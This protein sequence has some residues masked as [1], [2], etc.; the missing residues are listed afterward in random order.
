[1]T[2]GPIR[3]PPDAASGARRRQPS[4]AL[5]AILLAALALAFA[6]MAI[7]P[8]PVGVFQD[9]GI[10]T[11]L[12]K[13]LATGHGFRYLNIPGEPHATHYPPLYPMLLA[14]LWKLS[15]RFPENVL[16]FKLANAVLLAVA[17]AGAYLL[18]RSRVGLG[19][20]SAFL[21][22]AAFTACAPV[23]LLT[24][25]VLSEPMFLAALFPVLYIAERSAASGRNGDA[26]AAGAAGALLGLVRTLG[27]LVVP[28]TV[29]VLAWRRRWRAA[30]VVA[31][32]AAVVLAPWQVWAAAH[33]GEVPRVYL[34]KY[35]AYSTWLTDAVV[36]E[37]PVWV[38]KVAWFNLQR[39]VA[40]GWAT[41][42]V[43]P[44]PAAVRW[45]A[46]A[47]LSALFAGGWWRLVRR[48]PVVAWMMAAYLAVVV[49]WPFTPARFTWGIW[50]LVGCTF[51]LAID[52]LRRWKPPGAART[53][54]LAAMA[55]SLLLVAGYARYNWLGAARGWWTQVE[56][57]VADR[58]RPLGA[59]VMAN[60][61]PDDV[62]ATDDDLLIYLYTGRRAIPNGTFT[63]Q[64][65]LTPQTPDFAVRTLR[66][67]L[68]TYH[69]DW[70]L[71]ST[72]YG[73]YAARGLVEASPPELRI[74]RALSSGAVF[75]PVPRT[76]DR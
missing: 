39:I 58:A 56:K 72:Q 62:V 48:A 49:V 24:V 10:Y 55:A 38:A 22:A 36:G 63:P 50:P 71:A 2:G 35:G 51:G 1:M 52:G 31:L 43:D 68:A 74:V 3:H 26:V 32:S 11:V 69:V 12:A 61:G 7:S 37:G 33:A 70:V 4:E 14:A 41:V 40:Q 5:P 64:E 30:A 60:T 42:A 25:M 8:W 21:V 27:V 75:Q 18:A 46:T 59:W 47:V 34:G 19:R 54:R 67:I 65:H 15:P 17:A 23:I 73:T 53:L 66:E 20:G 29:L 6:A 28:A 9:D 16:V 45:T 76:E 13:A 44:F 57:S